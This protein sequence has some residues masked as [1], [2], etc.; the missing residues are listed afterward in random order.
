MRVVS[1]VSARVLKRAGLA[2]AAAIP[3]YD[4]HP[5]SCAY[6]LFRNY[7][8]LV[9]KP[10][11]CGTRQFCPSGRTIRARLGQKWALRAAEA[12]AAVPET[13]EVQ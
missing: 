7:S 10:V 4:V 11:K 3:N 6:H 1:A 12:D 5:H 13:P 9:M 2:K 8:S